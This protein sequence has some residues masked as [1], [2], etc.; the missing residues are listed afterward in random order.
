M[1][2][3]TDLGRNNRKN[4]QQSEYPPTKN[5]N[6]RLT[7]LNCTSKVLYPTF[8]VQFIHFEHGDYYF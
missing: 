8:E 6:P 7:I 1:K 2:K 4:R 3:K 5:K